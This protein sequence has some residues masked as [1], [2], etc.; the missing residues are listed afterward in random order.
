MFKVNDTVMLKRK[1]LYWVLAGS[2]TLNQVDSR[3]SE[4]DNVMR[5]RV[6]KID[7]AP[8]WGQILF[9]AVENQSPPAEAAFVSLLRH[10]DRCT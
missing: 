2:H 5:A 3:A 1:H 6:L 9:L 10:C 8:R 7:R 4:A